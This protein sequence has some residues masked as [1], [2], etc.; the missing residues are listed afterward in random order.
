MAKLPSATMAARVRQVAGIVDPGRIRFF[1]RKFRHPIRPTDRVV[2]VGSGGDPHPRADVLVD[3]S[4]AANFHRVNAFRR[5]APTVVADIVALPFRDAAFDYS[6]CS[7]VLEHLDDPVAAAAELTRISHAGYIET[8]TDLHEKLFPMTWHKWLVRRVDGR[9]RFEAK[10][11]PLLDERLGDWFNRRWAQDRTLMRFVWSHQDELYLQHQWRGTLDVE[12]VGA[13]PEWY[14]PEEQA[15]EWE[16]PEAD[17]SSGSR[18]LL[19]GLLTRLR[20]R[21]HERRGGR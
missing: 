1:G 11:T 15:A 21:R 14:T 18:R 12:C 4:V 13:P 9:L 6:I 8:P 3:N 20:Y 16:R 5:T 19:Y 10:Q 2:D 7:H 17:V